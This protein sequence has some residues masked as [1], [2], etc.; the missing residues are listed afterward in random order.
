MSMAAL[1]LCLVLFVF[2]AERNNTDIKSKGFIS[3]P[4]G[5][6]F[7]LGYISYYVILA[8]SLNTLPDPV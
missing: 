4:F 8:V 7:L 3:R 1:T 6:I 2:L 5:A